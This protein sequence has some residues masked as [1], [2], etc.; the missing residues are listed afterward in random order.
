MHELWL[1]GWVM[2]CPSLCSYHVKLCCQGIT[3]T[4]GTPLQNLLWLSNVLS[5]G[6]I[7]WCKGLRICLQ[8]HPQWLQLFILHI[9]HKVVVNKVNLGSKT[10]SKNYR[11][12]EVHY[13]IVHLQ[14]CLLSLCVCNL[15]SWKREIAQFGTWQLNSD[16]NPIK[17][18]NHNHLILDMYHDQLT[19]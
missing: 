6:I 11:L 10:K 7:V 4:D 13:T 16:F 2:P 5:T 9:C 3:G 19:L 14:T 1:L 18:F 17:T 15:T 8:R 12:M